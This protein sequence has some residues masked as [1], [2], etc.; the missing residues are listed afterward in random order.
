ML[1]QNDMGLTVFETD[2]TFKNFTKVELNENNTDINPESC[3]YK[4]KNHEKFINYLSIYTNKYKL[5]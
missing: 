3:N 2:A 5:L 1:K 4:N